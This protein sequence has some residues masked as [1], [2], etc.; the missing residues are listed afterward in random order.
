M[1]RFSRALGLCTVLESISILISPPLAGFLLDTTNNNFS[2]V[3]YMSSFFLISAAL[4][5]GG[6]FCA[7]QKKEKQGRQ[8][9]AEAATREAAPQRTLTVEGTDGSEK[10][11]CT[12]IMYVTSV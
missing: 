3:F 12:E 11:P 8:A 1:D 4:F 5:M 10:R 2:Y 6:S 9:E 7:L